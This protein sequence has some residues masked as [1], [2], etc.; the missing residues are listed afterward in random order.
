MVKKMLD[1]EIVNFT[2]NGIVKTNLTTGKSE[3]VVKS[4]YAKEMKYRPQSEGIYHSNL[5]SH[6]E[7]NSSEEKIQPN[8]KQP[9]AN[10]KNG[11]VPESDDDSPA[12]T[13]FKPNASGQAIHKRYQEYINSGTQKS[14][15]QI[16]AKA[17]SAAKVTS[18]QTDLLKKP[19]S[20][21]FK[22]LIFYYAQDS[23]LQDKD[24]DDDNP[25]TQAA[26]SNIRAI[27]KL[28]PI[29]KKI[30]HNNNTQNAASAFHTSAKSKAAAPAQK[31]AENANVF[32]QQKLNV[33]KRA[34]EK[35]Y[36]TAAGGGAAQKLSILKHPALI[37]ALLMVFGV[38]IAMV[39]PCAVI[40]EVFGSIF[41]GAQKEN[42]PQLTAYVKQLDDDFTAKITSLKENYEKDS[43]TEVTIQ[44][45]DVINTDPEALAIL[46]TGDWTDFT[47]TDANKSTIKNYYNIL[48]T[49]TVKTSDDKVNVSNGTSSSAAYTEH[50]ITIV[51]STSTA[52]DKINSFNFPDDKKKNVLDSLSVLSQTEGLGGDNDDIESLD[53][54]TSGNPGEAYDD[55]Q[56]K[57]IF[58]EA[59]KYLGY[60]Y[61]WGGSTP[62]TSFDCSGFVCWV[63]THS[64]VRNT[65]RT[66]AQGL[67]DECTPISQANAKPGDLIFFT[68]TYPTSNTVTHV[69]IYAGNDRMIHCG[70]PIHY[71]TL[72]KTYWKEHFYSFGRLK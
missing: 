40:G 27:S 9:H 16:P 52:E 2:R 54:G 35:T 53:S 21:R 71:T 45:S 72:N 49:Y 13:Y 29:V 4:D 36:K 32:R 26:K 59:E 6:A 37:K 50:H 44:G 28:S 43:H 70:D 23:I 14:I 25:A 42:S 62:K 64:G 20:K 22:E 66:S 17:E 58:T 61:V 57:K 34:A 1:K 41:G 10:P 56:A 38:F 47:L 15:K 51:I 63:F 48:N 3:L 7:N 31:S 55:P 5:H 67:Y 46:V 11:Y 24:D 65:P 12:L 60:K 19:K 39:I 8:K 69:G 68:K 30:K 18:S 33:A